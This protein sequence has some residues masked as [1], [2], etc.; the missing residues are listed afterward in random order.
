M[1]PNIRYVKWDAA[2]NHEIILLKIKQI[3]LRERYGE[4]EISYQVQWRMYLGS[5]MNQ[6]Q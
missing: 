4:G 3:L 1:L 2:I 6:I 5:E